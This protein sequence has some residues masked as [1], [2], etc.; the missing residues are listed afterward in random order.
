MSRVLS[1]ERREGSEVQRCKLAI[2]PWRTATRPS[3]QQFKTHSS[4]RV[5]LPGGKVEDEN[6][7]TVALCDAIA[8]IECEKGGW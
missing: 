2:G 1:H 3:H 4:A 7:I 6:E 8:G 5:T